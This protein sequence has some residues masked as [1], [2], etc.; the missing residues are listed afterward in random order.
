MKIL[1]AAHGYP[2][3][4]DGGTERHVQA[5]AEGLVGRGH[6]VCVVAGTLDWRS[7]LERS[8]E[9]LGGVRVVRI[10]RDDFHYERWDRCYH[11]RVSRMF[12]DLLAEF[13][14][15]VCHVHHWLRL[16]TDLVRQA[17]RQAVPA[18]LTLHDFTATCPTLHRIL[19]TGEW[20]SAAIDSAPCGKC[21][22]PAGAETDVPARLALRWKDL[23][24]EL[25]L[26]CRVFALS[27]S[28]AAR[29]RQVTGEPLADLD[30]LPFASSERLRRS[31]P[32]PPAPPMRVMTLGLVAEHKGQH[33]LLEA[34]RR[35][36]H[37]GEIE[38]HVFGEAKDADYDARLRRLADGLHVAWHGR[39]AFA[40]LER[41]PF[42]LAVLPSISHETYGLTLDEVRMLG[43]PA[44]V[45]DRGAYAERVGEG[46]ET[47]PAG[48]AEELARRLD[49]L[50][51]NPA[52]L[53]RMRTLVTDPPTFQDCLDHIE[54]HYVRAVAGGA[55]NKSDHFDLLA[56]LELEHR[57]SDRYERQANALAE[58]A[59]DGG[60]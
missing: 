7:C 32:P 20:C 60:S 10:H 18:L 3:E 31:P 33:V 39:Y 23:A 24:N 29:I 52:R 14:P 53:A 2:P 5:L 21:V 25:D 42:H 38:L 19:P 12:A 13:R 9:N 49:A 36:R 34:V 8:T 57:R 1:L 44:L 58:Q 40:D 48:D 26:A 43:L 46:G 54:G 41:D 28:Q 37:L 22:D 50:M 11:P 16:S 59:R 51:E 56:H 45:S 17:V 27:E 4:L 55:S 30:V 6:E 35:S 15:D 47:F